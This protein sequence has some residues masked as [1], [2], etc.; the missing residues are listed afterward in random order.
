MFNSINV[1]YECFFRSLASKMLVKLTPDLSYTYPRLGAAIIVQDNPINCG[2]STTT[3]LLLS[4][5]PY[6]E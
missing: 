5:S 4:L 6:H 2:T 1:F 3:L